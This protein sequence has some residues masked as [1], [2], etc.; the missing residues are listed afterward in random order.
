MWDAGDS[1]RDTETGASRH[2]AAGGKSSMKRK[3]EQTLA[4]LYLK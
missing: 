4:E 3:A 2:G 1:R